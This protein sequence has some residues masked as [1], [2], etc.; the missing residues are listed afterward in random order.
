MP[1]ITVA[2]SILSSDFARLADESS[3]MKECGADWLHVDCMDGHFVPNLTLGAPIVKSLRQHTDMF[4]DCHLM[5]TDPGKWIDDFANAG[6][7]GV[8]FHLEAFSSAP[9]DK[10]DPGDY[11][12]TLTDEQRANVVSVC[13]CIRTA[14]MRVG[15]ALRP[16]TQVSAAAFLLDENLIDLLLIMTV[17]PGFGGQKFMSCMMPKVR[18]ARQTYP[19]LNIEVDGG[20]APNTV[21]AVVHAGANVL[22]AGS[23]IF[24]SDN[25]KAVIQCLRNGGET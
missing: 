13:R 22:V 8:T 10:D 14:N 3:R 11:P 1:G 9:Y 18:I 5:V 2:P 6:A 19:D 7:N 17:E 23:A 15:L 25:P 20:I 12:C 24:G 21:N 16:R 4:L